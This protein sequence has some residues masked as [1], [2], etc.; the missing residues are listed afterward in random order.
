MIYTQVL[1]KNIWTKEGEPGPCHP[2]QLSVEDME[3]IAR[4]GLRDSA[5]GPRQAAEKLVNEW[6]KA[7]EKAFVKP[8]PGGL[9]IE[10]GL[11]SLLE[12]FEVFELVSEEQLE[13]VVLILKSVFSA[14]R[15]IVDSIHFGGLFD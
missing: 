11:I 2:A 1:K 8:E 6:V 9:L 5:D 14:R 10:I 13:P 12:R 4:N 7:Y 15:D 3:Y